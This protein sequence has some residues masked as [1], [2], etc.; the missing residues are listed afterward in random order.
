M[1]KAAVIFLLAWMVIPAVSQGLIPVKYGNKWGY[2]DSGGNLVINPQF[3]E[4][5]FF[6]GDIARVR[7]DRK[8]GFVKRDGT[9][10]V[11]CKYN[12]AEHERNGFAMF[13]EEVKV[14]GANVKHYYLLNRKGV[15]IN[16]DKPLGYITRV[17]EGTFGAQYVNEKEYIILDTN[18]KEV[19]P[20][21]FEFAVG[22]VNGIAVVKKN[23]F[24][25]PVNKEGKA[26]FESKFN[27]IFEIRENL[28]LV[29]DADNIC[30]VIDLQGNKL[31]EHEK[32]YPLITN[33]HYLIKSQLGKTVVTDLKGNNILIS[34][35]KIYYLSKEYFRYQDVNA[36]GLYGIMDIQGKIITQP[37]YQEVKSYRSVFIVKNKD[38][39][40]GVL[41]L[42]G[43]VII[44]FE[45]GNIKGQ[46][47]FLLVNP[48]AAKMD[49]YIYNMAGKKLLDDVCRPRDYGQIGHSFFLPANGY[50]FFNRSNEMELIDSTG[51]LYRENIISANSQRP[52]TT[53]I[54]KMRNQEGK[55]GFVNEFGEVVVPYQY[56]V[57]EVSNNGIMP[58]KQNGKWGYVTDKGELILPCD[59][60][61]AIYFVKEFGR[62][63]K[64]DVW[65]MVDT[66]GK[67]VLECK[68]SEVGYMSDGDLFGKLGSTTYTF[69]V[70]GK[71][72]GSYSDQQTQG[73]SGGNSGGASVDYCV[74][75]ILVKDQQSFGS[76]QKKVYLYMVQVT[77][78][79]GTAGR[80]QVI[81]AA[82]NVKNQK[83][84]GNY[85][86]L[87]VLVDSKDCLAAKALADDAGF[88]YDDFQ[89]DYI[90][91][92]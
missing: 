56:D 46:S 29:S 73:S 28:A 91:M 17:T 12:N 11:E 66:R 67:F 43:S 41:S 21:K 49:M 57:L 85:S 5:D 3:D 34:D 92:R 44:P 15:I 18:L 24:S 50:L 7:N 52:K 58:A 13:Y 86:E 69:N 90:K 42:T 37:I 62:V 14:N 10:A 80:D 20:E 88:T 22:F 16:K 27:S 60:D 4:A 72:T 65:G 75:F 77:D 32:Y 84:W 26:L 89:I 2:I 78:P 45:Y 6:T 19:L 40:Y 61:E 48:D 36:P 68:Y 76:T 51:T 70:S 82:R 30:Y 53:Q 38:G 87:N 64:G 9:M 63:R 83:N 33:W 23:G 1:K 54:K 59:Y 55:W 31:I 79:S 39:K 74:S 81:Q 35:K 47:S 8:F 71:Q 25:V